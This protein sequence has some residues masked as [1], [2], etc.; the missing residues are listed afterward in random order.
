LDLGTVY[1]PCAV[2][3]DDNLSGF[4]FILKLVHMR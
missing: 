2:M 4:N 3:V 1:C